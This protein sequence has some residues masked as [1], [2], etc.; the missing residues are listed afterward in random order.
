[1]HHVTQKSSSRNVTEEEEEKDEEGNE[2][3]R[4][5]QHVDAAAGPD[6]DAQF[7]PSHFTC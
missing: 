3:W 2:T 1:M 6:K 5:Q 4:S 7:M